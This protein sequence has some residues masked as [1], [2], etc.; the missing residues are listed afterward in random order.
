MKKHLLAEICVCLLIILFS[1]ASLTKII[2]HR[3][4]AFQLHL[5]PVEW[6]RTTTP[7]ISWAVPLFEMVLAIGLLF[8]SIRLKVLYA[9]L[10]LLVIFEFYIGS[11]LLSGYDLPCTCGGVIS[12]LSWKGHLLFNAVFISLALFA[13]TILKEKR[14]SDV[15]MT[16]PHKDLSRA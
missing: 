1:Y 15:K 9:S 3:H 4:F 5:V 12:K 6:I 11:L 10:C 8:S 14:V 16:E 2:D 7:F 13:I